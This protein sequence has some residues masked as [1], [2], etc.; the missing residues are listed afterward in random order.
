VIEIFDDLVDGYTLV[1]SIYDLIKINP[2]SRGYH[3]VL[4]GTKLL[5]K[6]SQGKYEKYTLTETTKEENIINYIKSG[7]LYMKKND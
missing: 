7:L 6:N 4:I 3:D 1:S 5:L 2:T